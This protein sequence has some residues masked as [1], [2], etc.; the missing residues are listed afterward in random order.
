VGGYRLV[1]C[2]DDS[3]VCFWTF[4]RKEVPPMNYHPSDIHREIKPTPSLNKIRPLY[5]LAI[6]GGQL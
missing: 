3:L 2:G 6:P 5:T 4:E 1:T